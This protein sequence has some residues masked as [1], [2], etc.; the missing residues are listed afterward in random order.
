MKPYLFEIFGF[1]IP[2]YGLMIILA[3]IAAYIYLSKKSKL[4][5]VDEKKISDIM[6]YSVVFGFVGAKLLYII[7]FW[8]YFGSDFKERF[9]NIFSFDNL[10]SGFVFYGGFVAGFL[11]FIWSVKRNKLDILSMA[12]LFAP[13]MA[14]SHAISRIGCFLAGCCHGKETDFFLGVVFTSPY[15]HVSDELIGKK[16]HPTQLYESV[17]NFVIF[18]FLNHMLL[19]VSKGR[20]FLLY[21]LLYSTLRFNIEFLRGDDRGLYIL[22]LSQAQVISLI[23]IMLSLLLWKKIPR[24]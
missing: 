20:I 18:L 24:K 9:L 8:S 17:G 1:K 4:Y 19:K 23:L 3:Y 13:A 11:G 12:D 15:C 16:I 6:F 21:I 10:R 14:L 5:N 2:S 7:T 22:G